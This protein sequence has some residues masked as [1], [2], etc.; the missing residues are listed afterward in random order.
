MSKILPLARLIGVIHDSDGEP[1][2]A[3]SLPQLVQNGRFTCPD[4]AVNDSQPALIADGILTF[5]YAF[6]VARSK[7]K[8]P[9]I[10]GGSEG[11]LFEVE[12]GSVHGDSGGRVNHLDMTPESIT[13]HRHTRCQDPKN[14]LPLALS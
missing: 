1:L 14:H 7:I 10:R 12:I 4:V 2:I 5:G 6:S 11:I 3:K 8:E 13:A 9:R